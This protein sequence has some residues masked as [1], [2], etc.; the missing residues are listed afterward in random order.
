MVNNMVF[1]LGGKWYFCGSCVF[2]IAGIEGPFRSREEADRAWIA[3][4]ALEDRL[5]ED[6]SVP[7][8]MFDCR[9]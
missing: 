2:P 6:N 3:R 7:L 4:W 5:F 9:G 1:E 8:Q